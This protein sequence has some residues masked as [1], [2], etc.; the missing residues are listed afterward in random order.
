MNQYHLAEINIAKMKGVDINDPIM[1]EFVDNL[2]LVNTLAEKSEGFVWRLKDDSSNATNLNP[3]N[4]EQI[5]VNV[6]FWENIE[7]LEGYMYKTFHSEFLK[8]RKEWFL[9]FGKAHTAMWWIPAGQ[10]P[11]LE[12]A[13]EKLD[14]LQQNGAS[15]IVFDLRNKFPA[16]NESKTK[17]K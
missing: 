8:R 14:Y 3:Y 16:P 10:I 5:I 11:T 13:V 4:D 15:E 1:K 17:A 6:S 12:E 9:K 2:D 7:T